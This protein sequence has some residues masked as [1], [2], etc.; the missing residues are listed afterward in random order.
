MVTLTGASVADLLE[1]VAPFS[2]LWSSTVTVLLSTVK[3]LVAA[4]SGYRGKRFG[5][6]WGIVLYAVP[7]INTDELQRMHWKL[8]TWTDEEV[9]RWK[10]SHLSSCGAIAVA[11]SR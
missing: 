8:N 7:V 5:P 4:G 3:F 2:I 6:F 10:D 11:V 1:T 9:L